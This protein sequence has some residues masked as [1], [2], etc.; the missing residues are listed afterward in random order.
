MSSRLGGWLVV[1]A[2]VILQFLLEVT[3]GRVLVAP[4]LVVPTLVYLSISREDY[5]SIEGA[6]W[7]GIVMDMLL[8]HPPGTS[9]LAMILGI[10]FS[11]WIMRITTGALRMTFAA[12]ALIASL[13]S[14]TIFIFLAY[15]PTGS[16]FSLKTLLILPRIAVPL[17][18]FLAIP[19]LLGG[20]IPEAEGSLR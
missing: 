13:V 7:T 9:S 12:N 10:S 19:L 11:G 6:F 8:H 3:L 14:D 17:F 5:W 18:L 15:S 20:K 1:S 16:G 2:A 4:A